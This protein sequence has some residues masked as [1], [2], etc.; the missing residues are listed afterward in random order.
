MIRSDLQV[1]QLLYV[2][3]FALVRGRTK[4][5]RFNQELR[6]NED[7]SGVMCTAVATPHATATGKSHKQP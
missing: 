6:F 3:P 7:Q 5:P 2:R 1:L 4:Q